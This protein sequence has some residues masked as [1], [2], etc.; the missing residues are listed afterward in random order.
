VSR[1]LVIDDGRS[2][3]E[4]LV[5]GT[6]VVGRDPECEISSGDPR[7]SRR[8]AELRETPTGVVVRDLGSRNGVRVNGTPVAEM[9]LSP[10]DVVTVAHLSLRLVDD[11]EAVAR[12]PRAAVTA[13]IVVTAPEEDDRTRALS[14]GA[15][16]PTA[17][18]VV[19]PRTG[20]RAD[21]ADDRT[22]VLPEGARRPAPAPT[23]A[24]AVVPADIG[25]IVIREAAGAAVP[26]ADP[27]G[28]DD[29]GVQALAGVGWGRR[30]L[31]QGV[32]LALVVFLMTVI[33][34]VAW[35]ARVFGASALSAWTVLLPPLGASA[36]A[37]AMVAGLIARTAVRGVRRDGRP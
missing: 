34:L 2:E 15:L 14:K 22:R 26:P 29:L 3:R 5:V 28:L 19:A 1:K 8:H 13:P 32:L 11:A 35:Q 17:A 4:L 10:G 18:H 23:A 31:V 37:G 12:A 36:F 20:L 6:M 25:E 7:L 21:A 27:R 9:V 33:P 16:A 30:V 24:M